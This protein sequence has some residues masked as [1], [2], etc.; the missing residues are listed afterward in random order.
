MLFFRS[1]GYHLRIF[2]HQI[3]FSF[4]LSALLEVWSLGEPRKPV[5]LSSLV[6]VACVLVFFQVFGFLGKQ[7]ED[8]VCFSLYFFLFC[9]LFKLNLKLCLFFCRLCLYSLVLFFRSLG[10]D[11]RIFNTRFCLAFFSQL[12]QMFGVS[13]SRGSR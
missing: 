9:L 11:L 5:I 4:F 8:L 2:R 10:Y 3:L 12:Y 1:L 6:L 13:E 7:T